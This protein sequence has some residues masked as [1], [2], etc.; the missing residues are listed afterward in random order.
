MNILAVIA[1]LQDCIFKTL[2][3]QE[4]F[5]SSSHCDVIVKETILL[6]S[7]LKTSK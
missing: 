2:L 1:V 5:I 6:T 7:L 4:C 3:Y